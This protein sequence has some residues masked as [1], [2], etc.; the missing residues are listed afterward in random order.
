MQSMSHNLP[1]FCTLTWLSYHEIENHLLL[2]RLS[3]LRSRR[4]SSESHACSSIFP[5]VLS[6][7]EI[8]QISIYKKWT[9]RWFLDP[10]LLTL[11][12]GWYPILALF[13]GVEEIMDGDIICFQRLV[14]AVFSSVTSFIRRLCLKSPL[15]RIYNISKRNFQSYFLVPRNF[16]KLMLQSPIPSHLDGFF[17]WL[18]SLRK[19]KKWNH[20]QWSCRVSNDH[21]MLSYGPVVNLMFVS[22]WRAW[23]V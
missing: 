7:S 5:A 1:L 17:N 20:K 8:W 4:Q 12:G 6:L 11:K 13:Q 14:M 10:N 19:G 15:R 3:A 2:T 22:A 9:I 23:D 21:A 16:F 18:T